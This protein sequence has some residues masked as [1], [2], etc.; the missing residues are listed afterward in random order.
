MLLAKWRDWGMSGLIEDPT[1]EGGRQTNK[2]KVPIPRRLDAADSP[3]CAS[4]VGP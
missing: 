1:F 3:R 2:N 4:G